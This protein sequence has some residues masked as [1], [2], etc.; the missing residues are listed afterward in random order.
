MHDPWEIGANR[1]AGVVVLPGGVRVR[2]RSLRRPLPPGPHPTY[3]LSLTGWPPPRT[4]WENT[5]VGWPDFGL[6]ARWQSAAA[7]LVNAY[8]A[9]G[10][11]RVEVACG[12]GRGRTG[13]GLACLAVCAGL[14][15]TSAVEYVRASDHPHAVET[16]WQAWYVEWFGRQ[17]LRAGR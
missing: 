10:T 7:A 1:S 6:P 4:P 12:G 3:G 11:Q 15:P 13:T 2:G 16:P 14:S 17:G 9:C 8:D 5:W